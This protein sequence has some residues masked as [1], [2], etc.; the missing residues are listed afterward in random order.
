MKTLTSNSSKKKGQLPC[1]DIQEYGHTLF[2]L[3]CNFNSKPKISRA[4]VN[5]V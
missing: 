4:T 5:L 3:K 1:L 2:E